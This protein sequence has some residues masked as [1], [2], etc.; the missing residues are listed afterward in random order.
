MGLNTSFTCDA[1]FHDWMKN[2]DLKKSF[3]LFKLCTICDIS[4]HGEPVSVTWWNRWSRNNLSK[5]RSPVSDQP[6]PTP[7]SGRSLITPNLQIIRK[8][9]PFSSSYTIVSHNG[10]NISDIRR[11]ATR[12]SALLNGSEIVRSW[13]LQRHRYGFIP[14]SLLAL[15]LDNVNNTIAYLRA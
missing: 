8:S 6:A 7:N 1:V 9:R 11:K 2:T 12:N 4:I 5:Y 15:M 10:V 3:T 13:W 14:Q